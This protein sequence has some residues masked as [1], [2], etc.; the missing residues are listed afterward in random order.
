MATQKAPHQGS[1]YTEIFE[2]G[3]DEFGTPVI[4]FD[5]T[6]DSSL[7][8]HPI[9]GDLKL[10]ITNKINNEDYNTFLTTYLS[11]T[12]VTVDKLVF[13]DGTIYSLPKGVV[14]SKRFGVIWYDGRVTTKVKVVLGAAVLAGAT[15]NTK[16]VYGI[17]EAPV[18]IQF[19]NY[20]TGLTI[21]SD[22]LNSAIVTPSADV[23]LAEGEY[24]CVI[25]LT[26]A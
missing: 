23:V 19:I 11:D 24:G 10:V 6:V 18:E 14:D 16:T 22:L 20:G 12:E 9:K 13:E 1:N 8:G 7:E 15:G 26:A 3:S 4:V 25:F 5:W 17:G 2:I 21:G